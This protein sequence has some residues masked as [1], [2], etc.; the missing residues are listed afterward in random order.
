[1]TIRHW[2]PTLYIAIMLTA[3]TLGVFVYLVNCEFINLDDNAYITANPSVQGG[4]TISGVRWAFTTTSQCNWH[5]LTWISHMI[6][7]SL[8]GLRPGGH[9]LT[10]IL[11]H[12]VNVLILFYVFRLM[13]GLVWQSAFVAA[14]FAVHP[15]HIESVAW[16]SERKDVLSTLFGLLSILAY[17]RYVRRPTLAGYA[18]TMALLAIGLMAK[19]MLVTFP[20]VLLI[21]DYWP[22]ERFG[23]VGFKR[24]LAEKLPML[25]LSIAS[26]VTTYIAQR[27]GRAVGS[28]EELSIVTRLENAV[29]SYVKYL[30]AAA[31][32]R[33]LAVF[34]P[35]PVNGIPAWQVTA[36]ILV[37]VGITLFVFRT[38]KSRPYAV[39]GWLWYCV[40]L[41]PVIGLVQVGRQAM[42]DRYTYIPLIGPFIGV[43]WGLLPCAGRVSSRRKSKRQ[44]V[45]IFAAFV[46]V[47]GLAASA[48]VQVHYW[49][50]SL[51]LFSRA[52][53][54]TRDNALAHAHLGLA[55]IEHGRP[56]EA[57][58]HYRAALRINRDYVQALVLL[59]AAIAEK[60][61]LEEA[62]RLLRRAVSLDP[63]HPDGQ[64]NLGAVLEKRGMPDEAFLH[65]QEAIK[66]K[67]DFAE[68]HLNLGALF[69][70][71]RMFEDA[72][73][74]FLK[75]REINPRNA[76]VHYDIGVVYNQLGK[77][78]EA[79]EAFREAL[80]L[81]PDLGQAHAGL[82]VS[83]FWQGDYAQAWEEVKQA[84]K[85]GVEP[86]PGL[87]ASLERRVPKHLLD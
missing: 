23:T 78:E 9:H 60:G 40:T 74:E 31:W 46:V 67:P 51:S 66:V 57:I 70:K 32:P 29:L 73:R 84:R 37:L 83:Y 68:A 56:D 72:E 1:M 27:Q 17:V 19:P 25:V 30:L 49:Q 75:A 38:A 45:A 35:H 4:L 14:L 18:L 20:M 77:T 15:L 42:A 64:N 41:V 16:V 33:N 48:F 28:L 76:D 10:N 44:P 53:C 8:Y 55:L 7:V 3:L 50:N 2:N 80:R 81:R 39:V 43:S 62:E 36:A 82:A 54:V 26:S 11:I 58:E 65:Y 52:V 69:V 71:Q 6:D 86:P 79:I 47:M 61:D 12:V 59:G 85:L 13:T 63:R 24:L 87:V 34:Y 21:L 5:P 22:L